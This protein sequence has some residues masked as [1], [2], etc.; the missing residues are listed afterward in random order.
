MKEGAKIIQQT[1]LL[2]KSRGFSYSFIFD[3]GK[4][5]N[6]IPNKAEQKKTKPRNESMKDGPLKSNHWKLIKQ[7]K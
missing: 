7:N 1:L 2:L 4:I 5:M 3:F 6:W